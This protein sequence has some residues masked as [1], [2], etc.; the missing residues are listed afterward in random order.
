MTATARP[1]AAQHTPHLHEGPYYARG[2]RIHVSAT[3]DVVFASDIAAKLNAHAALVAALR[4]IAD[5]PREQPVPQV[6][7]RLQRIARA[8][9]AAAGEGQ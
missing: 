3:N 9:L 6:I 7:V 5:H 4:E 8:A 2:G 1:A